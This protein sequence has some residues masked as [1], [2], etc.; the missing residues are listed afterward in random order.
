MKLESNILIRQSVHF[1]YFEI[2]KTYCGVGKISLTIFFVY[3]K[4]F[5]E[6]DK[7]E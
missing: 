3:L 5:A 1:F 6:F 4:I 2:R 7:E